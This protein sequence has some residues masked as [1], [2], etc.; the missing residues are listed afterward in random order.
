MITLSVLALL[1]GTA[2]DVELIKEEMA[3]I[4]KGLV[5][6]RMELRKAQALKAP[7]GKAEEATADTPAFRAYLEKDARLREIAGEQDDLRVRIEQTRA[8]FT[9]GDPKAAR[10]IDEASRRLD[11]L[12]KARKERQS[13]LLAAFRKAAAAD[14]SQREA[15]M[16]RLQAIL[17]RD[18]EGLRDKLKKAGR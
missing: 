9:A 7:G 15:Y 17:E 3:A 14:F 8:A 16:T 4:R 2:D 18:L 6:V 5:S 1:G 12:V 11:T 13:D 10:L